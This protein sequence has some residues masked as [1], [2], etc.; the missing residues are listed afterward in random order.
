MEA[1]A[2]IIGKLEKG[3]KVRVERI[4]G[5]VTTRGYL[6]DLGIKEG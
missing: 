4:E 5:G 2:E 6:E 3:Q 1:L